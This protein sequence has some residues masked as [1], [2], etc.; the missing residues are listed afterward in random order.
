M[1]HDFYAVSCLFTVPKSGRGHKNYSTSWINIINVYI[2][3]YNITNHEH[4]FFYQM[5]E[6]CFMCYFLFLGFKMQNL[7]RHFN[8]N[9]S[10]LESHHSVI[11][12]FYYMGNVH[13]I[14]RQTS[15]IL[16]IYVNFVNL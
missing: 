1:L 16:D 2:Y 15:D 6:S 5:F 10:K 13:L 14:L 8:R 12:K 9:R 3:N 7:I 11:S 4:D